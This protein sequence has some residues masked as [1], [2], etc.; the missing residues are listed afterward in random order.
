MRSEA[1]GEDIVDDDD[2]VDEDVDLHGGLAWPHGES[3][4]SV[5][6]MPVYQENNLCVCF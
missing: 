6:D 4:E 1:C 5:G 2:D 3:V